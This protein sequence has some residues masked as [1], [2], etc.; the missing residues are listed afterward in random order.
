MLKTLTLNWRRAYFILRFCHA[1]FSGFYPKHTLQ[2]VLSQPTH[3][4][5]WCHQTPPT[6][7]IFYMPN[8]FDTIS[9]Q[10]KESSSFGCRTSK[11]RAKPFSF[12][13]VCMCCVVYCVGVWTFSRI[14]ELQQSSELSPMLNLWGGKVK[15]SE[16]FYVIFACLLDL[17]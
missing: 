13:Q 16:V 15:W 4:H 5:G 10:A 11:S 3:L 2:C 14:F 8:S 1:Y 6:L 12:I 17:L 9:L 7:Y